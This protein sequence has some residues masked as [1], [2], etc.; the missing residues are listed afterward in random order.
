MKAFKFAAAML[1][2]ATTTA[3]ADLSSSAQMTMKIDH[4][5]TSHVHDL[6]DDKLTEEQAVHLKLI[7]HQSA[8]AATCEGFVLDA[9]KFG[10]AFKALAHEQEAEMSDDEKKYYERHLLVMYG[11][12]IGGALAGA[13]PNPAG[14]CAEAEEERADSENAEHLVWE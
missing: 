13:A 3:S 7:A 5:V 8:V 12:M 6:I 4:F 1:F 11:M 14:F 10:E 2:A 9:K